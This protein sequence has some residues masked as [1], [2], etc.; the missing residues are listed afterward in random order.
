[1]IFFYLWRSGLWRLLDREKWNYFLGRTGD[2][3]LLSR[4]YPLWR[5]LRFVDL[6][7]QRR[8]AAGAVAWLQYRVDL[9]D[10]RQG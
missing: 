1:M 6:L 2:P 7:F 5:S 10:G 3:L 8:R 9:Y 4:V